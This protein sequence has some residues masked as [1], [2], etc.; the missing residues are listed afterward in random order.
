MGHVR[1][2]TMG[3]VV[4]RF[5]RATRHQRAAPD[6]LGR[7]RHA[8]RERRHGAQGPSQGMDLRQHRRDEEAAPVDGAVARLEPRDRDLRPGLLQAPAAD[9]PRLPQGRAGRAQAIEGELGPG[10]H[11]RARQ[12]AGDRRPRLALRRAGRAARADAVV[13]Q[14]QQLFGGPAQRARQ[15][16]PLAGKSPADAEE[17]DRPLARA[18]WCAS[19]SIRRRRRTARASWRFSPRGRTPCSA[20]SSWRSRRTIRWRRRRRQ[21]N[22]KLAAFIDECKH[23]RHRAGRDRHR[24]EARLR[25]RHPR[26]ASVRS[27]LDSCRSTSR[28]SS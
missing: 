14:D 5:K 21:K 24:R 22:P 7:L 26:G 8:G 1:N 9:V 3:D 17:L 23:M 27:E 18:C 2:Y 20:R 28:T 16:R 19:R 10:R 12:R 13:L 4:A 11:D 6:G 25:H 15:A